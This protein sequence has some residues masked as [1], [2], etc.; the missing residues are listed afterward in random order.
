MLLVAA[1][2]VLAA[3]VCWLVGH[4]LGP[5][6]FVQRLAAAQPGDQV[7]IEL[8]LRARASLLT[9]PF[10]AIV[11][12]LLG[13]SLGP[14]DEEPKPLFKRRRRRP[15]QCSGSRRTASSADSLRHPVEVDIVVHQGRSVAHGDRGDDAV[16]LGSDGV[17]TLL[18]RPIDLGGQVEVILGDV[19]RHK[20]VVDPHD[21]APTEVLRVD[22]QF[23]PYRGAAKHLGGRL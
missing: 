13:S 12:V 21:P 9:W 22:H 14:D 20:A 2:A 10:L 11:P 6:D 7:P 3:L 17:A 4:Q 1:V 23:H 8:T 19:R 16:D 18:H 15:S 5:A